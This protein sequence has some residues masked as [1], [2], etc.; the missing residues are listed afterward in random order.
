MVRGSLVPPYVHP[1]QQAVLVVL[2][3]GGRGGSIGAAGKAMHRQPRAPRRYLPAEL[4]HM[5]R[6]RSTEEFS[7]PRSLRMWVLPPTTEPASCSESRYHSM[8][9]GPPAQREFLLYHRL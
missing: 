5:G 3:D 7:Q 8:N 6:G 4:G 9:G 2:C 1:H